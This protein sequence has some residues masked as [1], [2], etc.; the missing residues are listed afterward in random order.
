MQYQL[1]YD[2]EGNASL[3]EIEA[4]STRKISEGTFEVS[5]YFAP[6][7]DYGITE[8]YADKFSPQKQLELIQKKL[9]GEDSGNDK[10]DS[11]YKKNLSP[12]FDWKTYTYNEYVRVLGLDAADDWL[13]YSKLQDFAKAANWA[14]LVFPVNAIVKGALKGTEKFAESQKEKIVNRYLNSDYYTNKMKAMDLDYKTYG[15]YDVHSDIEYGPSYGKEITEGTIYDAEDHG[16]P[17]N[18]I[19]EK[20]EPISVP[21]PAHIS[22]GN[23]GGNVSRGRDTSQADAD[24]A[25][26]SA[27]S[28]PF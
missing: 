28:T 9:V 25:G 12:E 22:G 27:Y 11:T 23:N 1:Q 24:K 8:T 13:K 18:G 2:K 15:D 19:M 10:D 7:M 21:V 5:E 26:G 16:E 3:K 14:T 4:T 17:P 20:P 6:R